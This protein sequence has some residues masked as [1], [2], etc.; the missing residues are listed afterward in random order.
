M[1]CSVVK[2]CNGLGLVLSVREE[3]YSDQYLV[4]VNFTS[5]T[6]CRDDDY[7]TPVVFP[8]L[9]HCKECLINIFSC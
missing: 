4:N 5:Q 8:S 7:E 3:L 6:E 1:I 9:C 2:T